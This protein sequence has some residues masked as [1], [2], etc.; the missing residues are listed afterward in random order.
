MAKAT[1]KI[2]KVEAEEIEV[3]DAVDGAE[4]VVVADAPATDST[5]EPAVVE[6][7]VAGAAKP[8]AV[9]RLHF[10]GKN[11]PLHAINIAAEKNRIERAENSLQTAQRVLSTMFKRRGRSV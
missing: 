3:V 5:P 7:T 6:R 8:A 4:A 1:K 11:P 2:A 9:K 10:G